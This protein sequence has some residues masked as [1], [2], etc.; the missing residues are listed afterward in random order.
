[1]NYAQHGRDLAR[2][3]ELLDLKD[4]VLAPWSYGCLKV[5][6]MF[7]QRGTQGIAGVVWI[8]LAPQQIMIDEADWHEGDIAYLTAFQ[9]ALSD[10][11]REATREFCAAMWQGAAP[12][13]ELG[14]VADQSM[15]TPQ[16]A[17]CLLAA[18]GMSRDETDI[19]RATDGALPML[20]IVHEE[21]ADAARAFVAR[22]CPAGRVEALGFQ[23]MFWEYAQRFNALIESFLKENDL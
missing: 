10:R 8:D 19:A 23:F 20:H 3:I 2:V 13:D 17:A 18:D 14:W 9:R 1:V 22:N 5:W 6:E 7:R 16:Y 4:A 21:K 12:D 11:Y 15:Q